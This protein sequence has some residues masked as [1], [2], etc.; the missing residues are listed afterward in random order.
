MLISDVS[1][2][3]DNYAKEND[4][5]IETENQFYDIVSQLFGEEK[6]SWAKRSG[7]YQSWLDWDF[8]F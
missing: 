3:V 5:S 8:N 6:Q 7:L 1:F 4:I 2:A